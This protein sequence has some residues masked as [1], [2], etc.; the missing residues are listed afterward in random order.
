ML[1]PDPQNAFFVFQ[2]VKSSSVPCRR[3]LHF[4]GCGCF[5]DSVSQIKKKNVEVT[6][7]LDLRIF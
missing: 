4:N 3:R 1:E 5:M 2:I 6:F 7:F